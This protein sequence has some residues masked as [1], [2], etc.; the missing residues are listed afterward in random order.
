MP[1]LV[2]GAGR[3]AALVLRTRSHALTFDDDGRLR[4]GG[5]V[6][7]VVL[8][9][10][11]FGQSIPDVLERLLEQFLVEV[12]RGAASE[13]ETVCHQPGK[14]PPYHGFGSSSGSGAE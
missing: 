6:L 4:S 2:V 14:G 5:V 7:L 13:R 10:V 8:V 1:E 12:E 9:V 11:D 3:V